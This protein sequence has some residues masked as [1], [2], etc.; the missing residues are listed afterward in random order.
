M[1]RAG[2]LWIRKRNRQAAFSQW[3]GTRLAGDDNSILTRGDQY[4]TGGGGLAGWDGSS[5]GQPFIECLAC[6]GPGRAHA[7]GGVHLNKRT[8]SPIGFQPR[9]RHQSGV[10]H[11]TGRIARFAARTGNGNRV[12]GLVQAYAPGSGYIWRI[13]PPDSPL[14]GR[15]TL[16]AHNRGSFGLRNVAFPRNTSVC[17]SVLRTIG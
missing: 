5:L 3:Q 1:G 7:L 6:E 11:R 15:A 17:L 12:M 14:S 8:K 13:H 10:R 9:R 4:F 2:G 16:A